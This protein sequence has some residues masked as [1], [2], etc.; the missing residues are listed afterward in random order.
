MFLRSSCTLFFFL[1]G[2]FCFATTFTVTDE[3]YREY[4]KYHEETKISKD[5]LKGPYLIYN[6]EHKHY[7][8]VNQLGFKTCQVRME[9]SIR[10]EYD[11]KRCLP[12]KKFSSQ[13]DCFEKGQYKLAPKSKIFRYCKIEKKKD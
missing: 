1:I 5:F 13:K 4:K 6:C 10:D 2:Q 8:C 9:Q 3:E 7:M 11:L 12:I